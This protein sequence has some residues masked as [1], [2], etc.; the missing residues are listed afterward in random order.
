MF[1]PDFV[2]LENWHSC[3]VKPKSA[4]LLIFTCH[5]W[6]L[7]NKT[8]LVYAIIAKSLDIGKDTVAN[9]STLGVFRPLTNLSSLL[10]GLNDGTQRNHTDC[11]Q[12]SLLINLGNISPHG[13]EFSSSSWHWTTLP[14]PNL[15][16]ITQPVPFSPK[17]AQIVGISSE[18][19]EGPVSSPVPFCLDPLGDTNSVLIRS[20]APFVM[21]ISSSA[22]THLCS[23]NFFEKYHARISFS[24]KGETILEFDSSQSNKLG[25]LND[26]L[27]I[28]FLMILP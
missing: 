5:K 19:Q 21:L 9:L 28:L 20:S 13:D 25:E 2:N 24:Q 27:F 12:S 10:P 22:L 6:R 14:G 16:T 26:P 18:P 1:T 8:F 4:K 3:T 11:F 23:S 17:T 15:T 7:Q